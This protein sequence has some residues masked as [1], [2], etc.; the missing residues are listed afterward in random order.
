M[1]SFVLE[2]KNQFDRRRFKARFFEGFYP[3]LDEGFSSMEKVLEKKRKRSKK[4]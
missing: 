4:Y 2:I 1:S 3:E